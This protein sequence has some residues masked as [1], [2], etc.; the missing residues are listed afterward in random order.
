MFV[1]QELQRGGQVLARAALGVGRGHLVHLGHGGPRL[2][3]GALHG[4]LLADGQ[5]GDGGGTLAVRGADAVRT[6]VPAAEDHDVPPLRADRVGD[7]VAGG[8]VVGLDQVV[9]GQVDAV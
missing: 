1:A 8:G 2:V 7:L 5:G 6:G 4:Q 9:H 3:D